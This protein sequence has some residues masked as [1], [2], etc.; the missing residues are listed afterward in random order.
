MYRITQI[1]SLLSNS[2]SA[3]VKEWSKG[4]RKA[5]KI[6]Y[7]FLGLAVLFF[8]VC[9]ILAI[10]H[11]YTPISQPIKFIALCLTLLTQICALLSF[12]PDIIIGVYTLIMWRQHMLVSLTQEIEKD[13]RNAMR[14]MEFNEV[15]LQYAKYWIELKIARNE[16]RLK[17]FFG[18]KTAALALLGLSWPVIKEL[19]GL[20]WASSTFSHFLAPGH[21]LDTLIWI[22]LALLLGLSLGGVMMKNVNEKYKYQVSLI[23]L[24]LKLKITP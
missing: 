5:K 12:F 1:I 20:E 6:Q 13:E 8:V 14:L 16:S 3:S 24:A 15:E 4:E 17:L 10:I 2:K 18:D 22:F 23:E 7:W 9:A 19:G 21:V 11:N